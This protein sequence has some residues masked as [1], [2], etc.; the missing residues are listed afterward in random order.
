MNGRRAIRSHY[1]KLAIVVLG[2][3]TLESLD[4]TIRIVSVPSVMESIQH[5]RFLEL[6]DRWTGHVDAVHIPS[7][8]ASCRQRHSLA[9][10]KPIG[11]RR[12]AVK[13]MSESYLSSSPLS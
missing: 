10:P 3:F 6:S 13:L 12:L 7:V 5:D 11:G 8:R 1:A 2:E 9:G 4:V